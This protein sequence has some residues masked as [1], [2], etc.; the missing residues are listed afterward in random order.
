MQICFF[1]VITIHSPSFPRE[2]VYLYET[3]TPSSRTSLSGRVEM[4]YS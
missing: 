3:A 2:I 4:Q 1:G